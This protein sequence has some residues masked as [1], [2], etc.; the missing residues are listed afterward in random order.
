MK[1]QKDVILLA[2]KKANEHMVTWLLRVRHNVPWLYKHTSSYFIK[3]LRLCVLQGKQ[4][5][6]ILLE[7]NNKYMAIKNMSPILILYFIFTSKSA[8]CRESSDLTIGLPLCQLSQAKQF[9]IKDPA[10]PFDRQHQCREVIF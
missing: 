6:N 2:S 1:W 5:F 10:T 9:S 7:R 4:G 3:E 8:I